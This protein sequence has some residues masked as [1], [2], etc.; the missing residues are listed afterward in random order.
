[1]AG[2]VDDLERGVELGLL[3][4]KTGHGGGQLG[5]AGPFLR[6]I[7]LLEDSVAFLAVV[8]QGLNIGADLGQGGRVFSEQ[9][10]HLARL[11]EQRGHALDVARGVI[12]SD[13]GAPVWDARIA[14][15][16]AFCSH[17][18]KSRALSF[19]TPVACLAS[20][21][22]T[23]L[24]CLALSTSSHNCAVS[25]SKPACR[26][27]VMAA[28]SAVASPSV[29]LACRTRYEARCRAPDLTSSDSGSSVIIE[30]PFL[31]SVVEQLLPWYFDADD[32]KRRGVASIGKCRPIRCASVTQG[33]VIQA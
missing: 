29:Y 26:S 23:V 10:E 8:N 17:T 1:V 28:P 9:T 19:C 31:V 11:V 12:S 5:S 15:L 18:F 6:G 33:R 24:S 4:I 32:W 25:P 27:A 7:G 22:I 3:D 14:R 20:A 21:A 30:S 13:N 2:A 16:T